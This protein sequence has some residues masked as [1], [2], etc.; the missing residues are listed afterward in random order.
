MK[1][2]RYPLDDD[3]TI[4]RLYKW[5][6]IDYDPQNRLIKDFSLNEKIVS[7]ARRASGFYAIATLGMDMTA[8]F[9]QMKSQL[10]FDRQRNW[11]EEAKTGRLLILF[12]GAQIDIANAFGFKIL[13]GCTPKY[14][15]R[16]KDAPH[17][18]RPAKPKTSELEH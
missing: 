12:V 3:V 5:F 11:S 18:D 15:S 9:K 16:K 13:G 14:T 7:N 10:G 8:I 4:K 17:R 2:N 1:D 6:T